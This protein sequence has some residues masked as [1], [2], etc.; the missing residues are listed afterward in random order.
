VHSPWEGL[1]SAVRY[2]DADKRCCIYSTA[3]SAARCKD[4]I[5]W[6]FKELGE[7]MKLYGE[8]PAGGVAINAD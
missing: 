6:A 5:S 3:L 2:V 1:I 8:L 7:E 4:V